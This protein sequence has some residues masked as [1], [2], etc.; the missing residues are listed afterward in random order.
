ME[1]S[2][3]MNGGDGPK[4]YSQN[5]QIQAEGSDKVKELLT[6]SISGRLTPSPRQTFSIADLGCSV[7]PNT[8]S[9]MKTIIEAVNHKC[10]SKPLEFQVF[11]NDSADNDFNTLFQNLPVDK[12][13][14]AAGVPGSFH[15]R[16]FPKASIDLFHSAFALHWISKIPDEVLHRGNKGRI[17]YACSEDYVVEA[18]RDQFYKDVE[19]FLEARSVEMVED[20]LMVVLLP[21]RP[22]GSD[23][24]DSA[25][26]QVF[27]CLGRAMNEMVSEGSLE[28]ALVDSFNLPMY[29]PNIS[30][31][32]DA[33]ARNKNLTVE[34]LQESSYPIRCSNLVEARL[35]SLH[36]RAMLEGLIWQHMGHHLIDVLFEKFT[37]HLFEFSKTARFRSIEKLENLF[38]LVKKRKAVHH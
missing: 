26:I 6:G 30:E 18:Y 29:M 4:S 38:L 21:G 8:F 15:G 23:P 14:M 33:V 3:V 19:V 5:S 20:G 34:V 22:D 10:G 9:S 37:Q 16:L 24:R 35:G 2:V 32:R 11:F 28:E 13:Y 1:K 17:T 12:D 36:T 7:G 31:L 27:E 25:S